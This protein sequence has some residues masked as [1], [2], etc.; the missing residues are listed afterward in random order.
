MQNNINQIENCQFGCGQWLVD[1]YLNI[2]FLDFMF[3][4]QQQ[5][6]QEGVVYHVTDIGANCYFLKHD[7]ISGIPLPSGQFKTVYHSHFLEHIN[8]IDGYKFLN[9]CFRI[10]K[11][12]GTM[13][14][15]VPDLELWADAYINKKQEFLDWY[16]QSWLTGPVLYKTNAQIFMGA[17]HNHEHKMGYDFETLK[18]LLETIGFNSVTKTVYSQSNIP[19]IASLEQENPRKYESLC[20]ECVKP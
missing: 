6:I 10:M 18:H 15:L 3:A 8:N 5:S 13:R 1:N 9:E 16:K 20:V 2:D 4:Q 17:L 14:I 19:E 11:S 12:G 7:I